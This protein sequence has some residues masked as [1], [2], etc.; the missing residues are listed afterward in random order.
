[1][2]RN[3]HHLS[4]CAAN[5]SYYNIKTLIDSNV[6]VDEIS[7]ITNIIPKWRQILRFML[8]AFSECKFMSRYRRPPDENFATPNIK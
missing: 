8:R 3:E 5:R 7:R 2:P 1:M 6:F 4:S